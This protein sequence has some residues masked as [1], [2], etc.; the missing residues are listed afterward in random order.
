VQVDPY[1]AYGD[2]ESMHMHS[3]SAWENPNAFQKPVDLRTGPVNECDSPDVDG[4][5]SM[6]TIHD[7][8]SYW[9]PALYSTNPS[10]TVWADPSDIL[11]YYGSAGVDPNTVEAFPQNFTF[12]AGDPTATL[13]D[14]QDTDRVKWSCVAAAPRGVT[15]EVNKGPTIPHTCPKTLTYEHNGQ[16]VTRPFMLRL[17]VQFPSCINL[18]LGSV[19]NGQWNPDDREGI[20]WAYPEANLDEE[21]EY[22]LHCADPD[23]TPIPR[24]KIG[25]R[26]PL[27]SSI[28]ITTY[29]V[30]PNT[31][32]LTS[33]KVASDMLNMQNDGVSAHAD[34]MSGWSTGQLEDL[35]ENCYWDEHHGGTVGAPRN[36]GFISTGDEYYDE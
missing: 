24:V 29:M 7:K 23:M 18:N 19:E 12:R 11:V 13:D 1:G 31:W 5:G 21:A 36:C 3:F 27:S 6:P 10:T 9:V 25:Y 2:L 35:M 22:P 26:W 4:E 32:D 28:G 20:G 8:S 33:L 15:N 16:T 30:T 14:P 17:I 34:F